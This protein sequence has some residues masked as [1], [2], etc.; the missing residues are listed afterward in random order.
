MLPVL[1]PS[2]V[3][4]LTQISS[5]RL[6]SFCSCVTLYVPLGISGTDTLAVCGFVPDQSEVVVAEYLVP[7]TVFSVIR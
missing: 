2:V 5:Q 3:I 4:D 7:D 6:A 1:T